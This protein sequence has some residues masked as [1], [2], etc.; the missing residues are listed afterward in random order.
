MEASVRVERQRNSARNE[1]ND[2]SFICVICFYQR[3][4]VVL[5]PCGHLIMCF[6]CAQAC[7]SKPCAVCRRKVESMHLIYMT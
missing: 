6:D 5:L 2:E 7:V 4:E 3:R 1:I